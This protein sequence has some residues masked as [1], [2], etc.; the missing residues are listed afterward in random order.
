MVRAA[1]IVGLL[2]VLLVPAC[3][4]AN[5][6]TIAKVH[7]GC[8]VEVEGGFMLRLT[9]IKVPCAD[10][11]HGEEAYTYLKD[12]LEG[13]RVKLFTWT[14]DTT[15]AGIVRDKDGHA[16]GEIW[17]GPEFEYQINAEMLKLGLG[18]IDPIY[19]PDDK[20]DEYKSCE[21]EAR[22]NHQGI[23]ATIE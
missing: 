19:M 4:I 9:G 13:K 15:A 5:T 20:A 16:F 1:L 22:A 8:L 21:D 18:I 17:Y 6:V 23:W 3:T 14:R 7:E 10:E 2:V 11:P 12:A